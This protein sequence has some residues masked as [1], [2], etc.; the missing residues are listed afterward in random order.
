MKHWLCDG[1]PP[2]HLAS[3]WLLKEP[4]F[5]HPRTSPKDPRIIVSLIFP[6]QRFARQKMTDGH[7]SWSDRCDLARKPVTVELI[8]VFTN[9]L[10]NSDP[11][12]W[13]CRPAVLAI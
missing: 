9:L 1:A 12:T 8:E 13:K 11:A 3:S 6:L 2:G 5:A 7:A 4:G 10:M